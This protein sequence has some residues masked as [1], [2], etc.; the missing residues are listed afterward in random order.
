MTP[1]ARKLDLVEDT[2]VED[3]VDLLERVAGQNELVFRPHAMPKKRSKYCS[4]SVQIFDKIIQRDL[5]L[6]KKHST[7]TPRD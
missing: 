7:R 2:H 1:L 6:Q 3:G 5:R 4:S